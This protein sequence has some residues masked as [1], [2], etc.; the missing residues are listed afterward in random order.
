[1]KPNNVLLNWFIDD[2]D[3]FRLQKVAL[4]DTDCAL[5]LAGDKSLNAFMGNVMWRSPEGQ[6][7]VGIGKYSE[8]F[9]FGL[10][11]SNDHVPRISP[12][13]HMF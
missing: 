4:G 13:D 9:S 3:V 7:G 1:M 11:V 2:D 12:A 10:L 6:L 8:V 5:K